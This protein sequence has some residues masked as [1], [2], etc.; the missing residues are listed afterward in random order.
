VGLLGLGGIIGSGCLLLVFFVVVVVVFVW[1]FFFLLLLLSLGYNIFMM[2]LFQP[3]QEGEATGDLYE[4]IKEAAKEA[5]ETVK[6]IANHDAITK[7]FNSK[8]H[9]KCLKYSGII[10][11]NVKLILVT[12]KRL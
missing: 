9:S 3:K 5:L 10:H 7:G 4:K 1:L 8:V 2:L 12:M 6:A 11:K